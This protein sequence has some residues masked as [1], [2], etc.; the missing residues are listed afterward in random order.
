[1]NQIYR[2]YVCL[3]SDDNP[4]LRF[5]SKRAAVRGAL[6]PQISPFRRLK[7]KRKSG[8]DPAE[9]YPQSNKPFHGTQD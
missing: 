9:K 7:H 2:Y 1:M 4:M 6:F 3:Q 8:P 5:S